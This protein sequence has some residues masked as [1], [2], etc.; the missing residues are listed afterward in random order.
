MQ[1]EHRELVLKHEPR[2]ATLP[3]LLDVLLKKPVLDV[4]SA[5]DLLGSTYKTANAAIAKL[6][7]IGLVKEI[8]GRKRDRIYRY[9]PYLDILTPP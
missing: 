6:E 1:R 9:Q 8:T 2:N 3:V 5:A 7:T 4:Q